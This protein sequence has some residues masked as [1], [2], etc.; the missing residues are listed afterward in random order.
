M[1]T[2]EYVSW[3][4]IDDAICRITEKIKNSH[5]TPDV[6]IAIGRGGMIPAR[7]LADTLDVSM[8]SMVNAKLY[9]GIAS[10]N[11]KPQIGTLSIPLYNK[12][13]LLVDDIIAAQKLISILQAR[14]IHVPNDV[15][16]IAIGDEQD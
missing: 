14:R 7:L 16:I 10:R 6:I 11:S 15:A 12:D 4:Y 5:F 9:N 2:K 1:I 8:V 3:K 13:V